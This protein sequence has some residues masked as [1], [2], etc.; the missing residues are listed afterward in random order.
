[1]A[2]CTA[3]VGVINKT[4]IDKQIRC[5]DLVVVITNKRKCT[6]TML[7]NESVAD[8]APMEGNSP[9]RREAFAETNAGLW[10]DSGEG[11]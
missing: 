4:R 8:L 5:S 11:R 3:L 1:M 9:R 10:K 6:P 7:T 2:V